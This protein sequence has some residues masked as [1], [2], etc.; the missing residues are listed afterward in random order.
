MP[1]AGGLTLITGVGDVII[2]LIKSALFGLSAGLIACYKGISVGGGPGRRGQCG[3]R[4]S[5]VHLRG[6]VREI[7]IIAHRCGSAGN[8]VSQNVIRARFSPAVSPRLGLVGGL[9]PESGSRRSS[10]EETLRSRSGDAFVYYRLERDRA[11]ELRRWA[12]G[13]GALAVIGGTIVIVGFLTL[14]TGALRLRCRATTS[15]LR[16]A[17]RR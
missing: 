1:F 12:W 7:N 3:Q 2:S 9:G 16:W 14:T 10:T 17:W 8:P 6:V 15:S 5:G 11:V 4:D 13:L